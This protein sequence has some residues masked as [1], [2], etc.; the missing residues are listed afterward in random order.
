MNNDSF[1]I[2]DR[3]HIWS[4]KL[5][6]LQQ[7]LILIKKDLNSFPSFRK[8]IRLGRIIGLIVIR[9]SPQIHYSIHI[10]DNDIFLEKMFNF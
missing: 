3:M 8:S 1:L 7:L 6:K 10:I 2:V 9:P 5:K 4:Q